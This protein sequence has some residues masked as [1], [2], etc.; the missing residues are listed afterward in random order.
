M[1]QHSADSIRRLLNIKWANRKSPT[2]ALVLS[3]DA[4]KAFDWVEGGICLRLWK[5]TGLTLTILGVLKV[6]T[7]LLLL[8]WLPTA[9]SSMEEPDRGALFLLCFILAL[10]PL[11]IAT[12]EN[13]DIKGGTIANESHKLSLSANDV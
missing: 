5:N 6:Y 10:E 7:Q 9:L 12:R 4:E 8:V 2:A 3:L 11:A 1:Q 13:T